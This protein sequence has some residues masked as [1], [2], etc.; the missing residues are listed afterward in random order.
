MQRKMDE[1]DKNK[2]LAHQRGEAAVKKAEE[3]RRRAEELNL[4]AKYA[5]GGETRFG[6]LA[7]VCPATV[8]QILKT[9]IVFIHA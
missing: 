7:A 9:S 6:D 8:A 2:E 4:K 5:R 1:I 3:A